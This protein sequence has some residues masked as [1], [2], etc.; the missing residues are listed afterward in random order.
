[1]T[2]HEFPKGIAGF[3][4]PQERVQWD[5]L[6]VKEA[7]QGTGRRYRYLKKLLGVSNR[8]AFK[9][10][11]LSVPLKITKWVL[12][13]SSAALVIW[14]CWSSADL[15]VISPITLGAIGITIAAAVGMAL[16]IYIVGARI[17]RVVRW[18]DTL[19]RIVSGIGMSLL[20]FMAARVHL[21]IFDRYF[22]RFGNLDTFQSLER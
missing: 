10:W 15:V 5:F 2:E 4:E 7:M 3:P 9:I 13:G 21:H 11:Q 18:R 22:L 6:V 1:M 20:G 8:A 12:L 16:A 14:F 19:I 17:T